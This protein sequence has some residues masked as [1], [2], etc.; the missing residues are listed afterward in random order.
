MNAR[1]KTFLLVHGT[2]L[3]GWIWTPVVARL[4][5]GG[6]RVFAPTLTGCGERG[7]LLTPDI[8]LETHIQD[9]LAVTAA[10][11]LRDI[12]L[13]GH[14]FA[15]IT[16]TGAADRMRDKIRRLVFFDALI[17]TPARSAAIMP[18]PDGQWP[19][20]WQARQA[21]FVDGYK[22]DFFA[23]YEL[24]MLTNAPD[25]ALGQS[26]RRRVSYHPAKQWTDQL[27][28]RNGGWEGLARTYWHCAGQIHRPSS[29]A[30]FGPAKGPGWDYQD[31]PFDRTPMLAEPDA[32]AEALA[33]LI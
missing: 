11:E 2:W 15:G 19:Q 1:G 8:G 18:E 28:L 16:I 13:V 30:M 31:L 22:M 10:E 7:H 12:I 23:D 4:R 5:A 3:G 17:P 29:P 20:S 21:K 6:A 33:G 24:A 27:S 25:S 14:S 9:I 32:V 26:I